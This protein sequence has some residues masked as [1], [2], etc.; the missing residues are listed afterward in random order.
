MV[1][2]VVG[3]NLSGELFFSELT[4]LPLSKQA[5]WMWFFSSVPDPHSSFLSITAKETVRAREPRIS[6]REE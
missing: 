2:G 1:Q 3:R 6:T 4:A 5:T